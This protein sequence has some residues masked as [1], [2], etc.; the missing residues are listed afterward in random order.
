VETLLIFHGD[1]KYLIFVSI[2]PFCTKNSLLLNERSLD[3]RLC[4]YTSHRDPKHLRMYVGT[5]SFVR[6]YMGLRKHQTFLSLMS[7]YKRQPN[8]GPGHWYQ[9]LVT[10]TLKKKTG[11]FPLDT[12]FFTNKNLTTFTDAYMPRNLKQKVSILLRLD[13]LNNSTGQENT[14]E[15]AQKLATVCDTWCGVAAFTR[16]W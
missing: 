13:I 12:F 1:P 8:Q 3:S 2:T 16:I 4:F 10:Y 6:T 9:H 14:Y 15:T 7:W 5:Y 11:T